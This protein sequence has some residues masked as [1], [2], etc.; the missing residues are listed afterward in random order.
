MARQYTPTFYVTDGRY[1]YFQTYDEDEAY[2]K[3]D[4]LQKSDRE[5]YERWIRRCGY[6]P[7][8]VDIPNGYYVTTNRYN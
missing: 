6:I 2:R 3:I 7:A 4:E 8:D 1:N 5:C